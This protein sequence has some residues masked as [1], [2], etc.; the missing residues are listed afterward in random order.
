MRKYWFALIQLL[1]LVLALAFIIVFGNPEWNTRYGFP[2]EADW[3]E[4]RTGMTEEEVVLL[5]GEPVE[6]K[7]FRHADGTMSHAVLCYSAPIIPKVHYALYRVILGVD[8]RLID[9]ERRW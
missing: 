2:K 3:F 9:S 4:L 5:L 7:V 1:L 8:N 6:K